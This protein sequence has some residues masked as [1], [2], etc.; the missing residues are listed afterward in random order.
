MHEG[1]PHCDM[2]GVV[3]DYTRISV[4]DYSIMTDDILTTHICPREVLVS[5]PQ[6][7][8]DADHI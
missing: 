8:E 2:I 7:N 5:L 3:P 4:H 6:A 1:T